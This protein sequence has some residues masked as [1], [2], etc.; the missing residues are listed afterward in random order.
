MKRHGIGLNALLMDREPLIRRTEVPTMD[1]VATSSAGATL[2]LAPL[3]ITRG[4]LLDFADHPLAIMRNLIQTH[5]PVAA[6]E[7]DGQRLYFGFGP[8][9]NQQ[10]LSQPDLFHARFFAIR[11]PRQSAQRRL[12]GA[13][14]SM[15]GEEHKRHRRMVMAP[16]QKQAVASYRDALV[17]LVEELAQVWHAGQE[18]DLHD[19]MTRYMLRVASSI[20]FGFDLPELSFEI[21]EWTQRWVSR[22]HE[23]GVG[24][25]VP[26]AEITEEYEG[27]LRMAETLEGHILEMIAH[28]RRSGAPGHDV[29]SLLIRAHDQAGEQISDAELIGQA[30]ILFG[31]AHLTTANTLSWSLF[32][33][34]QHP[35]V[36]TELVAELSR[37]LGGQPPTV[38]QLDRLPVLDRVVRESMRVLP[39]SAYV[40]RIAT[41]PVALG[42]FELAKGAIVIFSQFITHHM[43]ELYPDPERF[44]PERWKTINPSPYAFLPFGAGP[45]MCLGGPLALITIKITLAVLLQRFHF[46]VVPG[47]TVEGKVISTMLTPAAALP[48]LLTEPSVPFRYAPVVGNI[49]EL[50][51]LESEE[52]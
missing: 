50:M 41:Q 40:Q 45:R 42:P 21:G 33:L 31:A 28:R 46:R 12:T 52:V 44:R 3:P 51:E 19:E 7:Q 37:V 15:N 32:L 43:A 48:V 49:H 20:L 25:I 17:G 35:A 26:N 30:A 14:L 34:A 2:D 27:L 16:F 4:R 22:N 8:D 10:L 23:L 11:G 1:P 9:F 24:A 18:H 29:L 47:S 39:A 38:A 13:L 36:A 5:G 6:L